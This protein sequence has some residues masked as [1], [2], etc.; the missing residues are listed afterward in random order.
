[1]SF[2]YLKIRIVITK[3]SNSSED[4]YSSDS[5]SD[6]DS[7]SSSEDEE[8]IVND[9][10]RLLIEKRKFEVAKSE[11]KLKSDLQYQNGTSPNNPKE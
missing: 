11:T 2:L 7:Y 1:M 3:M 4:E 10:F 6:S 5:D 8:T 9:T